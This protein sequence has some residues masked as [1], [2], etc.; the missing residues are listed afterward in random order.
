MPGV[1]GGAMLVFVPAVAMFAI[2]T[3][4]GGGSTELI[5]NTIQKQFTSGKNQPFGAA[6]GTLL[7]GVF[8][9]AFALAGRF[10]TDGGKPEPLKH[11]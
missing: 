6:L 8:L 9:V 7:L 2:V 3:L 11:S 1:A 10:R 4:M 5:G